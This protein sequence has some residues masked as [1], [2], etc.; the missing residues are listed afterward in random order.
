M[1]APAS[2]QSAHPLQY[3]RIVVDHHDQVAIGCIHK[4][5]SGGG[6]FADFRPRGN[7]RHRDGKARSL[8]QYRRQTH[9]MVEQLAQPVNNGEPETKTGAPVVTRCAKAIELA[10]DVLLLILRNPRSAIPNLDTQVDTPL[11]P[12]HHPP[13]PLLWKRTAF[14]TKLKTMRHSSMKSLRTQARL[15]TTR[16]DSPF[17]R[18][19]PVKVVSTRSSSFATGNSAMLGVSTPAS[20]L[21]MSKSALNSSFIAESAAS[22]RATI[23]LRSPA[24]I[25]PCNCAMKSPNACNGCRKSWL[26]A[27][28]KRDFA[29]LASSS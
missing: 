10:E 21:E 23:R 24:R 15:E 11:P 7:V 12:T 1:I 8:P 2:K 3:E 22:M 26:A 29:R 6:R 4:R 9:R 17:S 28:K 5:M 14:E 25:R 13:P 16:N 27:A 20:S 18:A 19:A